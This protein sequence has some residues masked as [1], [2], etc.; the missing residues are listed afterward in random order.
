MVE[1]IRWRLNARRPADSITLLRNYY[2]FTPDL[3]TIWPEE[4]LFG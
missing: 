2:R 3:D 4:G 1:V